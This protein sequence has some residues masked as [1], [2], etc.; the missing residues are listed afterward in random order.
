M[1]FMDFKPP[2]RGESFKEFVSRV[3]GSATIFLAHVRVLGACRSWR[4]GK[5]QPITFSVERVILCSLPLAVAATYQ[6]V[7][8]EEEEEEDGL[9][10]GRI[11]FHHNSL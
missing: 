8:E 3:E 7:M 10:D 1:L 11:E 4:D 2:A 9:Y 5:L 6:M